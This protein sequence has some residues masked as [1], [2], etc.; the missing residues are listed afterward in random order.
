[1]RGRLL[2][3]GFLLARLLLH[4]DQGVI[5]IEHGCLSFVKDHHVF[6]LEI[7]WLKN[8]VLAIER[9]ERNICGEV[10]IKFTTS[11]IVITSQYMKAWHCGVDDV[12][13]LFI[14]I[15]SLFHIKTSDFLSV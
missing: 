12:Y 8:N 10:E 13:K 4:G 2:I 7:F 5:I 15:D 9:W 1:M 14:Y 11:Q 6:L 3:C